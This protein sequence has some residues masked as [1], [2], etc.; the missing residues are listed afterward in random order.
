MS[1][2]IKCLNEENVRLLCSFINKAF[3]KDEI[4][5][6]INIKSD[7]V[8][9]SYYTTKLLQ[10]LKTDNENY[11]N[12]VFGGLTHL[13]CEE[14][15]ILP[16]LDNTEINTLYLYSATST[17]P[18]QQYLK[19]S[20][21][22]TEK[23]IDLGSTSISLSEYMKAIDI[24]NI[25]TTKI[26]TQAIID[27][28][29]SPSD[30]ETTAKDTLVSAINEIKEELDEKKG[31]KDNSF[32]D[33]YGFD[34]NFKPSSDFKTL[35]ISPK[36]HSLYTLEVTE[37]NAEL[38]IYRKDSTLP[39]LV[40]YGNGTVKTVNDTVKPI[41][42]TGI[43]IIRVK[44]GY[45]DIEGENVNKVSIT[46]IQAGFVDDCYNLYRH[47]KGTTLDLSNFDT[48]N[49]NNMAYMFAFC[50]SLKTIKLG[51]KFITTNVNQYDSMF[52]PQNTQLSKIQIPADFPAESKTFLEARLA[53]AGILANVTF[54]TY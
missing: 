21:G 1:Q 18:Y 8:F 3:S 43:Y 19:I 2:K 17:A 5:D 23:L 27:T 14:T 42:N 51:N 53:E 52:T 16:T 32:T 54:E 24:A 29:G 46:D 38:A 12:T 26:E 22:T 39:M 41:Y 36:E 48:S 15:N 47:F 34:Y 31:I 35:V 11:T 49:V 25:Y 28:I 40:D 10:Q 20:D 30:L 50:F 33:E 44:N 37:D 4:I 9:S 45:V 13:T 7:G 6:D